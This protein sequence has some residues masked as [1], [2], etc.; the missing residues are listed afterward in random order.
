M[1]AP[2]LKTEITPLRGGRL[3]LNQKNFGAR[4][5]FRMAVVRSK[6]FGDDVAH[7]KAD[8]AC[9]ALCGLRLGCDPSR[10]GCS[11][12]DR[13]GDEPFHSCP[14]DSSFRCSVFGII[15]IS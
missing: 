7:C 1:F 11:D 14:A 5:A 4:C 10:E 15:C 13:C 8:S 9:R 2:V 3:E 12:L 6:G